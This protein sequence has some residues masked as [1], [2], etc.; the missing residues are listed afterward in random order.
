[1]KQKIFN[2]YTTEIA[3]TFNIKEV[4]LFQKS[5]R[6]EIVDARHTLYLACSSRP[7]RVVYIQNYMKDRGYSTGHSSIL[8]GIE[9]ASIRKNED[10]DY[11]RFINSLLDNDVIN[12][13]FR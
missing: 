10:K 13:L 12:G 5:K 2:H 11:S 3:E 7:M 4:E 8:Y 6:R 9:R 1:M